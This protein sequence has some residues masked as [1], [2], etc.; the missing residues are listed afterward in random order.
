MSDSSHAISQ[1]G[2]LHLLNDSSHRFVLI[3]LIGLRFTIHDLRVP[4]CL[5]FAVHFNSRLKRL[6]QYSSSLF[7]KRSEARF[8]FCSGARVHDDDFSGGGHGLASV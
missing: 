6:R 4:G 7:Q 1:V 3:A 5:L 8:L 2:K